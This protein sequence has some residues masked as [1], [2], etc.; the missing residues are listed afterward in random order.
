[1]SCNKGPPSPSHHSVG[2]ARTL[3]ACLRGREIRQ[4]NLTLGLA[5]AAAGERGFLEEET[6]RSFGPW[7][8]PP[9]PPPP[10]EPSNFRSRAANSSIATCSAVFLFSLLPLLLLLLPLPLPLLVL[11]LLVLVTSSALDKRLAVG[12]GATEREASLRSR[13]AN[14]SIATAW[15]DFFGGRFVLS[16]GCGVRG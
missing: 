6:T 9:P 15:A 10:A 7:E 2:R 11:L 13:A 5:A 14:S 1:M 4:P 16:S 8:S 12:G 3:L